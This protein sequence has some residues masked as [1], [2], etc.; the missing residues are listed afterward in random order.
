M[1]VGVWGVEEGGVSEEL[2]GGVFRG[3][4]WEEQS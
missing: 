3:D 1:K 2:V 4:V